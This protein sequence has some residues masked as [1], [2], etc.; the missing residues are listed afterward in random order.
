MGF[1]TWWLLGAAFGSNNRGFLGSNIGPVAR[2]QSSV[3][4]TRTEAGVT[5]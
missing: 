1:G 3:M 5:T 2:L 4:T